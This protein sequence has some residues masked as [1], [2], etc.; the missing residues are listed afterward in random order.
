M[1]KNNV[2]NRSFRG[3]FAAISTTVVLLMAGSV[4]VSAQDEPMT[5]PEIAPEYPGGTVAMLSYIQQN[6]KYPEGA[7]EQ[8]IQG[9]VIVQFTI[10]KDGTVSD[11]NVV[12]SVDPLVDAE[13]VRIVSNMPAWKPG[14]HEG[15]PVRVSYSIPIR[16]R[17]QAP[18]KDIILVKYTIGQDG[19]KVVT[20]TLTSEKKLTEQ[21][22]AS[23]IQMKDLDSK[24]K[25]LGKKKTEGFFALSNNPDTMDEFNA[26]EEKLNNIKGI[27][28]SYKQK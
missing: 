18:P 26:V 3:L 10:E 6:L 16:F 14:M 24:L 17:L 23:K 9:R 2:I 28:V 4:N 22:L 1:K 7:K 12:K 19:K 11:V 8:E 13:V 27:N 21:E 5:Q 25:E 15:K 20:C